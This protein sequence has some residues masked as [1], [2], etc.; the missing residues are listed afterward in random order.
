MRSVRLLLIVVL[1]GVPLASPGSVAADGAKRTDQRPT[2]TP[3]PER[4]PRDGGDEDAIGR[5]FK[6]IGKSRREHKDDGKDGDRGLNDGSSQ[7]G[8]D[9][10]GKRERPR[11]RNDGS[12]SRPR[13]D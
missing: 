10:S 11:D 12:S 2:P 3:V 6:S 1:A 5:V 8:K 7:E 4:R 9:D 13:Q